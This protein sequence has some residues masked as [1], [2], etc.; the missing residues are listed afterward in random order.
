MSRFVT[1][2]DGKTY[3]TSRA[4][5]GQPHI[6]I[7]RQ[8]FDVGTTTYGEKIV[9]ILEL[10][11]A[12]GEYE[13][14]AHET[15]TDPYELSLTYSGYKHGR[16][17]SG[18][19]G[20]AEALAELDPAKGIADEVPELIRL[21]DLHLSM[22][23]ATC[24]H[25]PAYENRKIDT[26]EIDIPGETV[27]VPG[28]VGTHNPSAGR[29]YETW[30]EAWRRVYADYIAACPLGYSPGS[31]HLVKQI[32]DADVAAILRLTGGGIYTPDY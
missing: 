9:V 31:K 12:R 18:G 29:R 16:M 23:T 13:S 21:S 3:D 2:D 28:F 1:R 24:D 15:L 25:Q 17:E 30:T 22:M 32:S 5:G 11:Q 27:A 7:T 6:V 4:S 19:C 26:M 14:T 10:S 8:K 20:V